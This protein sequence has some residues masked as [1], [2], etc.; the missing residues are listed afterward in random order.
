M[1]NAF[2]STLGYAST[3]TSESCRHHVVHDR[4]WHLIDPMGYP[5]TE[6]EARQRMD[7]AEW[8]ELRESDP[9]W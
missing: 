7:D 4:G 6:D 9:D 3:G 1:T 2:P 5:V 8:D